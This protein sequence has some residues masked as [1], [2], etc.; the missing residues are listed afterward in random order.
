MPQMAHHFLNCSY[1]NH[2]LEKRMSIPEMIVELIRLYIEFLSVL[3]WPAITL[4]IIGLV[5]YLFRKL[6]RSVSPGRRVPITWKGIHTLLSNLESQLLTYSASTPE[7]LHRQEMV[8]HEL[9]IAREAAER[10]DHHTMIQSIATLTQMAGQN[11]RQ[12]QNWQ[13]T[14]NQLHTN[15]QANKPSLPDADCSHPE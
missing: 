9:R 4:L 5:W 3:I 1:D 8:K 15:I 13:I 2:V 11:D 6:F 14:N 7:E 10:R 12:A